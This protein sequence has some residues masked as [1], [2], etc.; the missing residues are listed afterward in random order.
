VGDEQLGRDLTVRQPGRDLAEHL[1]LAPG[2][3]AGAGTVRPG[4]G[5][6]LPPAPPVEPLVHPAPAPGPSGIAPLTMTS[7]RR[8]CIPGSSRALPCDT[9]DTASR[10]SA[11]PASLVR[12]PRAPARSAA[13]TDASSE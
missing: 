7:T 8:R 10:M 4:A 6:T 13:S 3:T 12:K 9:A 11:A 1:R 5:P 2:Q